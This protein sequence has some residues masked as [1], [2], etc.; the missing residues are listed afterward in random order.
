[1]VA[2]RFMSGPPFEPM[3]GLLAVE[4]PRSAQWRQV[5]GMARTK[6]GATFTARASQSP[7]RKWLLA[8]PQSSW[9]I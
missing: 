1:M 4:V 5:V 2:T 8:T 7:D 3:K 9:K 6:K